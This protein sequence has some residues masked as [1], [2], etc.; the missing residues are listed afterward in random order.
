MS[1]LLPC[2]GCVV[3][4]RVRDHDAA[5]AGL[6]A[7]DVAGEVDPAQLLLGDA[8]CRPGPCRR[9]CRRRPGSAWRVARMAL[10]GSDAG[11]S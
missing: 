5:D 2:I 10:P 3:P 8:R 4:A 6:E 1:A 11:A 9:R 7:G